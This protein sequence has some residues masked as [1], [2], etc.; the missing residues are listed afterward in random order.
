[1]IQLLGVEGCRDRTIDNGGSEAEF[2]HQPLQGQPLQ[3]APQQLI[4]ILRNQLFQH[5]PAD[6]AGYLAC[7]LSI[8][9]DPSRSPYPPESQSAP[10][11]S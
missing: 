10:S 2:A 1:M 7:D 4:S 11:P 9:L 5:V 6:L 3:A 8:P